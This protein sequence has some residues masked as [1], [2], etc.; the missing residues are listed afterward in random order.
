MQHRGGRGGETGR[1]LETP[2][3]PEEKDGQEERIVRSCAI[4]AA[5]GASVGGE[6]KRAECLEPSPAGR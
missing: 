1:D 4:T 2:G 5:T 3:L 6:A